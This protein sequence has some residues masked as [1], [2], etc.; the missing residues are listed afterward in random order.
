MLFLLGLFALSPNLHSSITNNGIGANAF[1][2][3][4]E[5]SGPSFFEEWDFYGSWDNLTLGAPVLKL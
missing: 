3:I 2:V 4:K 1:D 5:Y